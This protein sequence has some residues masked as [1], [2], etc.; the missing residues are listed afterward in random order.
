MKKRMIPAFAERPMGQRVFGGLD[1]LAGS[2][3]LDI[4]KG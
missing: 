4:S 1:R 3:R 2:Q